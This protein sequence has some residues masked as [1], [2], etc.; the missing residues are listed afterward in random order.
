[1]PMS[2]P[3]VQRLLR[4]GGMALSRPQHTITSLDPDYAVKKRRL[5]T[6]AMT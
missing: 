6:P 1:M 5:K 4:A 3:S 2:V